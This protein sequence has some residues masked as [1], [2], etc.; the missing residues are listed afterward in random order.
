M[1]IVIGLFVVMTFG[2][3]LLT[4]VLAAFHIQY[5]PSPDYIVNVKY[6]AMVS[7]AVCAMFGFTQVANLPFDETKESGLKHFLGVLLSPVL[8]AIVG[9]QFVSTTIPLG[10]A[11]L[12]DKDVSITFT[13][14]FP[15]YIG[16]KFCER[17]IGL[18]GMPTLSN[19]LCNFPLSFQQQ[20]RSGSKIVVE[21]RGTEWGLFARSAH[22]L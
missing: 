21:G 1:Q 13:V 10:A 2:V 16:G 9:H 5:L 17:P 20:L 6:Y 3:L 14:A 22:I 11:L 4:Y 18:A 7:A 19:T 15:E 12:S 8:F